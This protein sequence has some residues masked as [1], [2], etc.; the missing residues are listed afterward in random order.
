MIHKK[1][2][3]TEW[4]DQKSIELNYSDKNL[5]EKVIRAFSLL[6]MLA[7][8]GCPFHFKGGSSLML[9]LNDSTHR[10]S[11]DID[12][13]CPPGTNI[14]D[15]LAEY[16]N[17]GFINYEL[18]ER[19]QAGKDVPKDH[20][21]FFYK[22][23]FNADLDR[24]SFILLDVL[25]EDCHYQQVE[26]VPIVHGLIESAG[27][28]V[29][30]NAPSIGD[31][32]GDKLTAYAPDTTGIPYFKG[33]NLTTL[34]VIKQ[35]YDI[36]RLFDRV[37]DLSVTATAF[38]KIAPVELSYRGMDTSD[39]TPIYEDIRSTSLNIATRG[40]VHK[41]KF[42]LLQKGI[43]NIKPFMYKSQYRIEEAIAD[44]A[45][46]AYL[47]TSIELGRESLEHYESPAQIL[48]ATIGK[49]YTTKLNKL[50][51]NN[52]EA[53]FYWWKTEELLSSK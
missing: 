38:C 28:K 26:R 44:A 10:L 6:D 22:V 11:I 42:D 35:L 50:K 1:C 9:L 4:I 8:S 21:K 53:F 24:Q 36:G 52:P 27:E 31:I 2:F 23:A 30:V 16:A 41:E 37:T 12:I 40:L 34:E 18:I 13:M 49:V 46:A 33:E 51:M 14:E 5:I 29:Y 48:D 20:S 17:S 25:Y 19:K 43:K 7:S 47:A 45:K 3:T 15:Y 32:L 39:L